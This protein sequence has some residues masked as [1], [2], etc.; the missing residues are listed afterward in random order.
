MERR[1]WKK[2]MVAVVH[3][4]STSAT[5]LRQEHGKRLVRE[6]HGQNINER[7]QQN[8]LAQYRQE[9][10]GFRVAQGD[11]RLLAGD[12]HTEHTSAAM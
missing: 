8:D 5:G 7:D 4:A 6:E 2:N 10:G 12:L 3:T 11:E 9:E 1:N